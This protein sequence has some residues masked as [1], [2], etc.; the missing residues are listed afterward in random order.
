VIGIRA[1]VAGVC[2]VVVLGPAATAGPAPSYP[3][4]VLTTR[5]ANEQAAADESDRLIAA[6]GD[7]LAGLNVGAVRSDSAPVPGLAKPDESTTMGEP[8]LTRTAWWTVTVTPKA[9]AGA[10]SASPPAGTTDQNGSAWGEGRVAKRRYLFGIFGAPSTDAYAAPELDI[11][12]EATDGGA[13]LIADTYISPRAARTL[14]SYVTDSVTRIDVTGR[15]T[16]WR[17]GTTKRLD[18]AITGRG[19][20][21]SFVTALD[22]LPGVALYQGVHSCPMPMTQAKLRLTLPTS[23]GAVVVRADDGPCGWTLG[24]HRDG[25]RQ[26]PRLDPAAMTSRLQKLLSR[27]GA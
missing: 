9:L 16:S 2:A 6:L 13:A 15:V 17:S 10:L 27:A 5:A 14:G 12:V 3:T 18:E 20:I 4:P 22:E 25:K 1:A 26:G 19:A 7:A 23:G 8:S 11:E 21:D 24:V